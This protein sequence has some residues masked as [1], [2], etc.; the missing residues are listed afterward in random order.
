MTPP[1]G[2]P[3]AVPDPPRCPLTG[4]PAKRRIQRVSSSLLIDLWRIAFRVDTRRQL[5][6]VDWFGLWE[7]PCGL[8]FFDPM[9]AGDEAFYRDLYGKLGELG[10]WT[11]TRYGGSDYERA[12]PL[13]APGDCV[14][15]VGCGPAGFA[16]FIPR[17]H[18][19]GLDPGAPQAA[20]L[21]IRRD[22]VAAHAD[23]HAGEYD[24]VSAFHVLE[25]LADP[26]RVAADMLRCLRP[27][28]RLIVAVPGWPGAMTDIPNLSLNGPPHHLSWWTL[29]ALRALAEGLS[30]PI[31]T[32]EALPPSSRIGRLY[33][34][35]WLAPK[36]TGERFFRHAWGWHLGLL[37][38]WLGG[39]VCTALFAR[40]TR[41]RPF[42][43]LL[44]AR[45]PG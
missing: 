8:A 19:V 36:V 1:A 30:A 16:R 26:A 34:M 31:E 18:Y 17:A 24:V 40:P 13:V 5:G 12:A 10:P 11:K 4:L 28:G 21:D 45:K 14:L 43:L 44:V 9:I 25:H 39:L 41:G 42:E 6:V 35:G 15:D 38:S 37:W 2:P 27:G 23:A 22:S 33:W 3:A 7:A 32:I 29:D 20:G